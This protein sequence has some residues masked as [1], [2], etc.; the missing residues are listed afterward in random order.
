MFL[1]FLEFDINLTRAMQ[2]P[3]GDAHLLRE[4][5]KC[6]NGLGFCLFENILLVGLEGLQRYAQLC[7]YVMT[8]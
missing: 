2:I 1:E 7:S 6:N 8:P 4:F 5:V 3:L